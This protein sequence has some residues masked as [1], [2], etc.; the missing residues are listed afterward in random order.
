LSRV[1]AEKTHPI[2]ICQL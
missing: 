1:K 2:N